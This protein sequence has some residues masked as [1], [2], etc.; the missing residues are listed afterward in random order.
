M[1]KKFVIKKKSLKKKSVNLET[2]SETAKTPSISSVPAEKKVEPC[3]PLEQLKTVPVSF[4]ELVE[5]KPQ[6][7][8]RG[9]PRKEENQTANTAAR[10]NTSTPQSIDSSI[11]ANASEIPNAATTGFPPES[12]NFIARLPG[13]LLATYFKAPELSITKDQAKIMEEPLDGVLAEVL[14]GIMRENPKWVMLII[15]ASAA[16]G[17][18]VAKF[19]ERKNKEKEKDEKLD[20]RRKNS[21]VKKKA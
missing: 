4:D 15:A 20:E 8:G 17:P 2:E 7:R 13:A 3:Q 19:V 10:E 6:K 9:R 16:Y 5:K 1:K 21:E 11:A 18:G 14:P 12:L